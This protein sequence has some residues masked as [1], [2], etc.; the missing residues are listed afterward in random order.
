MRIFNSSLLLITLFILYP[1]EKLRADN[2]FVVNGNPALCEAIYNLIK[3]KPDYYYSNGDF[4]ELISDD[5]AHV[6]LTPVDKHSYLDQ[7]LFKYRERLDQSP[8]LRDRLL[9]DMERIKSI[10]LGDSVE[11]FITAPYDFNRDGADDKYFVQKV[12]NRRGTQYYFS[13]FSDDNQ[14]LRSMFEG[15]PFLYKGELHYGIF[16]KGYAVAIYP[17]ALPDAQGSPSEVKPAVCRYR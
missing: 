12:T 2:N 13:R 4:I 16:Q 7:F 1:G 9:A 15:S 5:F 11:T 3:T 10:Y 6:E 14:A 17:A 8:S